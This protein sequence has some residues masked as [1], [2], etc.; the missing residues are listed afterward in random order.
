MILL[1]PEKTDVEFE[2]VARVLTAMGG[3]IKRLGKYWIKDET[4]IDRPL[5]I[6][7]NQTF[8]MVLAQIY[9]RTLISPDDTLI[10]RLEPQWVKRV[11]HHT[12]IGAL[13]AADFPLFI[14]PV[15]PKLF[16][17]GIFPDLAYFRQAIGSQDE[18]EEVL[19]S[20]IVKPI[21][22]ELRAF[23]LAGAIKDLALYEGDADL[24][25]GREFLLRFLASYNEQLPATVVVDL[26]FN[27][28]LGWFVL[29]FNASWG[30]GLNGCKAEKVIDC[31]LAATI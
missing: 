10:A 11:I 25:G 23:V 21:Q 15:I 27:E 3:K 31:I 28:A 5:A 22:A 24:A 2:A 1:I 14:K 19:T 30:A 17:A 20:E 18:T 9:K 4:L 6:Y 12:T 16:A 7:G 13:Q 8:A 26:G 29:E